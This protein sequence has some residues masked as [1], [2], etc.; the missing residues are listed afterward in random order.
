MNEEV[1]RILKQKSPAEALR[2]I[3]QAIA[4]TQ[5]LID[6]ESRYSPEFRNIKLLAD[7]GDHLAK[8]QLYRVE[9]QSC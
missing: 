1:L 7:Y 3:D 6:K 8:L 4:E 5:R 2:R 9:I